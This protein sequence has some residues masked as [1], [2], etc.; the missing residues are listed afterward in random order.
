MLHPLCSWGYT[1]ANERCL[2][3]ELWG[4]LS[5]H[6]H[7]FLGSVT[8]YDIVEGRIQRSALAADGNAE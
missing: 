5:E 6:I 1:G 7:M 2:A 8:L 3:H 4:D